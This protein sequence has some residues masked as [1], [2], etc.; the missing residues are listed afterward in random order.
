MKIKATGNLR[1]IA[2]SAWISTTGEIV[3]KK[4]S[5]EDVQKVTK[6]LA[7]HMH[8]S[9]F[10][11]VTLE[12]SSLY[13]YD[14][15]IFKSSGFSRYYFDD[16]SYKHVVTI[17]LWNFSKL[18]HLDRFSAKSHSAWNF[19]KQQHKSLHEV[20]SLFDFNN[21]EEPPSSADGE[22]GGGHSMAVEMISYHKS[23]TTSS[24]R[25]TWRVKCP[26]S[27]AVQILRHRT[28]S[29]NMVSGRYKTIKASSLEV[30]D[31][32]SDI[33]SKFYGSFKKDY[34]D[35]MESLNSLYNEFM[36]E[37]KKA[38]KNKTIS[39]TEYKRFREF[40]RFVLPEGRYT[41]LYITFYESDFEGFLK[42]RDSSHAQTE[43][44]WI[45][46]NMKKT[47]ENYKKN[48]DLE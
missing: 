25:A 15:E 6:F 30:V 5:Y 43:H 48:N 45:A 2:D 19:F 23:K 35:T 13:P 28:G 42:L 17:D 11:C 22:L 7:K 1:S 3:A 37:A 34:T 31:D 12:L 39:N 29:F 24:C 33:S 16:I 38:K 20:V 10:E 14:L 18:C 41:E 47:L 32:I 44:V 4:R 27:I 9:P 40:A 21:N 36:L 8:T 26:L 46:Q